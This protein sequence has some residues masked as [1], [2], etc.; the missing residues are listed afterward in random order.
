MRFSPGS[1][2]SRS[3]S[4]CTGSTRRWPAELRFISPTPVECQSRPAEF[5]LLK[6]EVWTDVGIFPEFEREIMLERQREGVAKA[7]AE[8]KY[9]YKGRVP[10]AQ[11]EGG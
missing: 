7:K 2:T 10:V 3:P 1:S 4:S 8:G 11:K 9:K 5:Q 6:S